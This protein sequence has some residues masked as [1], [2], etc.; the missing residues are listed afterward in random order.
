MSGWEEIRSAAELSLRCESLL[1]RPEAT[2]R[3]FPFYAERFRSGL[4]SP[5]YVQ[6]GNAEAPEAFASVITL[7]F[8]PGRIGVVTDG[9][10]SLRNSP[11]SV[12][13]IRSFR[14]WAKRNGY[15]FV[16]FTSRS[17]EFH[18]ALSN[19]DDVETYNPLPSIFT[20]TTELF[21]ELVEDAKMLASFSR[22]RRQEVCYALAAGY[23]IESG[24]SPEMLRRLW[25]LVEEMSKRKDRYHAPLE[26][27]VRLMEAAQPYG[28][29]QVY[30][31]FLSAEPVG[32]L[33]VLR[34]SR[35]AHACVAALATERLGDAASPSCLLY[36][37]AMREAWRSGLQFFNMG[38][39][40]GPV[41][42][43]KRKFHP[44]DIVYPE[45]RVL[46]LNKFLYEMWKDGLPLFSSGHSFLRKAS[47]I[48]H[49]F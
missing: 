7:G 33:L 30:G 4:V 6:Y 26:G 19:I 13:Q 12:E 39:P 11:I 46:V 31:A 38:S 44:T 35:I 17:M 23:E 32:M 40:S 16:R 41:C 43:F 48:M 22:T 9:P 10:V 49:R 5:V 24:D 1:Q 45:P 2:I 27:F 25:P 18:E 14:H 8:V 29:A 21:V 42:T 47:I 34:D 36:W 20:P 3:Q 28:C 37:T 15:I